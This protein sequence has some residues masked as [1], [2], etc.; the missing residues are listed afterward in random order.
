MEGIPVAVLASG[1]LLY[2]TDGRQVYGVAF[3]LDRLELRGDPATIASEMRNNGA[4]IADASF[5]AAGSMIYW[6]DGGASRRGYWVDRGG[7]ARL[8]DPAWRTPV[9]EAPAISPDG[10]QVALSSGQGLEVKQLDEG[11]ATQIVRPIPGRNHLRP[12]WNPDGRSLLFYRSGEKDSVL[13]VRA[14]GVG[15]LAATVDE[16]RGVADAIW[17]PDGRWVVFRTSV[18]GQN[19]ADIYAKLVGSDDPPIPVVTSAGSDVTPEF[20]PD[21]RWIAYASSEGGTFEIYLRPFP[22]V[23]DRRVQ[24][25]VRGGRQ[26]R[27]SRRSGELFY[28]GAEEMMM[29]VR[30]RTSPTLEV[31]TPVPLFR[32]TPYYIS[33]AFHRNFDVD[34][35]G[36]RFMMFGTGGLP[37]VVRI[38]NWLV[39]YPELRR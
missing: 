30:I 12:A 26:P 39:D 28:V 25:S 21:G 10:R 5:S 35:D 15:G 8:I 13:Q 27:W 6:S 32:V 36:Q 34:A 23:E 16:S 9:A 19:G 18:E 17:S 2:T 38:D 14:D 7:M 11:P 20:S 1:T 31:G 37:Q 24:V 29:A 4:T 33:T 3:D 22:N